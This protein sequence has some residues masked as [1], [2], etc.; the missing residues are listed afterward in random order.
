MSYGTVG[1]SHPGFRLQSRRR[2]Q[3]ALRA[4][5]RD[6]AIELLSGQPCR[7]QAL[8]HVRRQHGNRKDGDHEKQTAKS[9]YRH[10]TIEHTQY[11]FFLR[12]SL[13]AGL[14]S[15][16]R[17]HL[18]SDA[19]AQVMLEQPLEKKSGVR[20]GPPGSRRLVYFLDD[21]NMPFV[22]KYD[23]QSAIELARQFVDYKG[24]YIRFPL[25]R[26]TSDVTPGV[27]GMIR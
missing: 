2:F 14:S 1:E 7:E 17:R 16:R 23:T 9:G 27:L 8:R 24:W 22:D 6:N 15:T 18:Q 10:H 13:R 26:Q 21:L 4:N 5:R 3:F 19:L 25:A 11:E 20:F 12:C